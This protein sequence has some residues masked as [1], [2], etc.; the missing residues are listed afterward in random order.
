MEKIKNIEFLRFVFIMI[1]V[2]SHLR[3]GVFDMDKLDV[4]KEFIVNSGWAWIICDYFFILSGFFLFLKTDFTTSFGKFAAKKFFRF[5]PVIYFVLL[6]LWGVSFFTPIGYAKYDNLFLIL[7]IHCTGLTFHGGGIGSVWFVSSLFWALCFY[8]Y[9]YKIID[10]RFFNLITACLIF[11]CYGIYLHADLEHYQNFANLFNIGFC[12]A[13]GGIGIGYFLSELY[14]NNIERIKLKNLNFL[15]K[16]C[17]TFTECYLFLFLIRYLVLGRMHY[18][19][20]LIMIP[21]FIGLFILFV[22]KKGYFSKLA[23]NNLSVFFGKFTYSILVSHQ[24]IKDLWVCFVCQKY[25]NWVLNHPYINLEILL[26]LIILF[27][28]LIY[29]FVEKPSYKYLKTK[30]GL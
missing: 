27:S 25:P 5:M 28:M 15:Q 12:R 7:N 23:D 16:I 29:Y 14:K 3:F 17:M 10:K 20:F 19:N 21:P 11:F 24:L 22:I 30:F 9:L 1:I 2:W 13:F 6:L 18:D 26:L 8:F 4:Y